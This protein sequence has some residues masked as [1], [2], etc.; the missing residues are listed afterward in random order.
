MY[1]FYRNTNNI[2]IMNGKIVHILML[3]HYGLAELLNIWLI[4]A[5]AKFYFMLGLFDGFDILCYVFL[6]SFSQDSIKQ[7]SFKN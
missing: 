4:I 7:K 2:V 5:D 1:N 3:I 6:L